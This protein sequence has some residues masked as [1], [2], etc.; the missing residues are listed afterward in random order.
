V[1]FFDHLV[2]V[3]PKSIQGLASK[4]FHPERWHGGELEGVVGLRNDRFRQ[5]E[6]NLVHVDIEGRGELDVSDGVPPQDVVHQ[7]RDK[8]VVFDLAIELDSL[9]KRGGAVS[10]TY[11]SDSYFSI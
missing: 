2:H 1:G 8:G 4:H 3:L 11:Q 9:H 6:A 5:I 10:Y 7:A